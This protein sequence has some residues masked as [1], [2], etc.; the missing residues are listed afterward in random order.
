M[1]ARLLCE[2]DLAI[3][4]SRTEGFG[5]T[6]LEALSAGLPVLV[7]GNSGLGEALR[8]VPTGSTCVVDS[9]DPKDWAKEIRAVRQK[10]RDVRLAKSKLLCVKYLE[11]YSWQ[12][13]CGF[14][15]KKMQD[16]VFGKFL[17]FTINCNDNNDSITLFRTYCCMLRVAV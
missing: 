11:K 5:L 1:L 4:P 9:E 14:L 6:A 8:K 7:S 12:E 2:V 10:D 16:L 3:M 17:Y 13:P 15:V